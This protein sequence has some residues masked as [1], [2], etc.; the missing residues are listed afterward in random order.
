MIKVIIVD[1]EKHVLTRINNQINWDKLGVV[2]VAMAS[3]G[4]EAHNKIQQHS[5]DLVLVD[6]KMPIMSGLDLIKKCRENQMNKLKFIIISGYNDFSYAKHAL[7]YGVSDY[8][9]KPVDEI[10][11]ETAIMRVIDNSDWVLSP[12]LMSKG[13]AVVKVVQYIEENYSPIIT[14][15]DLAQHCCLNPSY[16]SRIFADKMGMSIF[17]H[18]EK[19]RICKAKQI[20]KQS[21][22]Y[23]GEVSLRCGYSDS[24]YFSKIFLKHVGISP[25]QYRNSGE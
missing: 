13:N 4:N 20:L 24:S 5:P 15:K 11:L 9:E 6:I 12:D 19:I 22:L 8:I 7:Q 16:L 23:I 3:N 1:D 14:L 18:L 25:T 21:N 2:V 10:E 17:A